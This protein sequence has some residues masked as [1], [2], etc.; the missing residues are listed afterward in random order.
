MNHVFPLSENVKVDMEVP[1]YGILLVIPHEQWGVDKM[2][3]AQV[4]I[5]YIKIISAN[6]KPNLT[7]I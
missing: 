7:A 3:I 5:D 2:D 6:F 4:T 1:F